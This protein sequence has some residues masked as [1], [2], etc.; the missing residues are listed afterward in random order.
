MPRQLIP[1]EPWWAE[2]ADL[3]VRYDISLREATAE[4]G[5]NLTIDQAD[6][7]LKRKL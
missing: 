4:L 3:M 5:T 2:A 7:I 6:A 1:P